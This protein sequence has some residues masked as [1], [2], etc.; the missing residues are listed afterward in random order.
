[1][2]KVNSLN[3]LESFLT[4]QQSLVKEIVVDSVSDI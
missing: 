3:K 4:K 1:M 2:F